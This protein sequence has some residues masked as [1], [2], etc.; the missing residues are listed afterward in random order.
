M[1]AGSPPPAALGNGTVP[2]FNLPPQV[3]AGA[4]AATAFTLCF[5]ICFWSIPITFCVSFCLHSSR[6]THLYGQ[7]IAAMRTLASQQ[8]PGSPESLQ[9]LADAAHLELLQE[10]F[11]RL[12][13]V[14]RVMMDNGS[15]GQHSY[16][17]APSLD[18]KQAAAN[19]RQALLAQHSTG[20]IAQMRQDARCHFIKDGIFVAVGIPAVCIAVMIFLN[21]SYNAHAPA[22]PPAMVAGG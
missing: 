1:A 14:E 9:L 7:R 19:E 21:L 10:D 6:V 13:A 3:V 8:P 12:N 5:L 18:E 16:R 2:V 22:S 15:R 11:N 17:P 4:R 20:E